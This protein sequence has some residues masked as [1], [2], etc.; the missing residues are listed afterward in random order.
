MNKRKVT[1]FVLTLALLI[2]TSPLQHTVQAVET[3]SAAKKL[4]EYIDFINS[5]DDAHW[6]AGVNESTLI[7]AV[8]AGDYSKGLTSHTCYGKDGKQLR[9][10]DE[11]LSTSHLRQNGCTT[12]CFAGA[13]QCYGFAKYLTYVLYGSYPKLGN[14]SSL[15]TAT[16][17]ENWTYYYK[18]TSSYPGVQLGDMIV[19]SGHAAVVNYVSNGVIYGVDCNRSTNDDGACKIYTNYSIN[20]NTF[21]SNYDSG[22]YYICRYGGSISVNNGTRGSTGIPISVSSIVDYEHYKV[23]STNAVLS[24]RLTITGAST[25]SITEDGIEL[26]D[27]AGTVLASKS[28]GSS[29]SGSYSYV[30]I[31]FDVNNSLGYTLSPETTYQYRCYVVINGQRYDGSKYTF[32]TPGTST[33]STKPTISLDKTSLS[34]NDSACVSLNATTVPDNQAVKWSSSDSSVASVDQYGNITA[35]KAGTTTITATMSYGNGEYYTY[36]KVTVTATPKVEPTISL[37]R[38]NYSLDVGAAGQLTATTTP[39]GQ[40]VTWSSSNPSVAYVDNGGVNARKSGTTTVTATMTYGGKTYSASCVVEVRGTASVSFDV[41]NSRQSIGTTNATLAN[42]GTVSGTPVANVS[43]IGIYLYDASGRQLATKS[44]PVSFS[45][46]YNYFDGW[47][48]VNNSLGV[49]LSPG[50]TYQYKFYCVIGSQT[51]EGQMFSFTTGG[52]TPTPT[53]APSTSNPVAPPVD[54]KFEVNSSRQS[55]ST[56]NATLANRMTVSGTSVTNVGR[57]G[58]YLY[59]AS[60]NQL[61]TKS[62]TS[63]FSGNYNYFDAWYNVNSSLGV[64]LNQNTTYQYRFY[65]EIGGQTYTGPMYSFTTEKAAASAPTTPA[66]TSP[67]ISVSFTVNNNRQSIG[68]TDATLANRGTVSGTSVANVS[69][70]GIFLYDASG[71]YLTAKS[72]FVNFSGNYNYFDGWYNV[73]SSLGY[74]LSPSTTYQYKFVCVI[75]GQLYEGPMYSFTTGA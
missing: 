25:A 51:Y 24:S 69:V 66:S 41:N 48:N 44:E 16:K 53:P 71:N 43:R 54:V 5:Y 70:I 23:E 75:D 18:S 4:Q 32:T 62:E 21:K 33:S 45:G 6:N 58:I 30:R 27:A 9:G 40:T 29:F 59:D 35:L 14:I 60:G 61:A 2:G 65:C 49:T 17:H 57:F 22:R 12:N 38:S 50:T 13:Y 52:E 67:A 68:R 39:A 42:R 20:E 19:L 63:S 26:R 47:Y 36:C 7:A 31:W 1:A 74:T 73:N 55:I 56:T 37:N 15:P 10:T 34:L 64:T 72:E 8:K 28:E 3:S 46:R 11:K